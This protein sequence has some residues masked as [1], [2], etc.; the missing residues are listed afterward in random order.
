MLEKEKFESYF[1]ENKKHQERET[2]EKIS[3]RDFFDKLAKGMLV[4]GLGG[5]E[6]VLSS[7]CAAKKLV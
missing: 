7:G 5:I 4:L 6:S 3:R 1:K 2:L